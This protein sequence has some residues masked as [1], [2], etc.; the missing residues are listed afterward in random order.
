M[1]KKHIIMIVCIIAM[2]F[3]GCQSTKNLPPGHRRP[4]K[5]KI[6]EVSVEAEVA[7]INLQERV[8]TLKDAE[9]RLVTLQV[10]NHVKRFDEIEKGD[11]VKAEYTTYLLSEF[12]D[13][14]P[15]EYQNPLVVI[16]DGVVASEDLPPE[17]AAGILVKAVVTVEA[18]DIDAKLVAVKGPRGRHVILPAEDISLL[19][20]LKI[21]ERVVITYIEAMALSLEKI[22]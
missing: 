22:R 16:S 20:D 11:I 2:I 8:L 9:G 10:G 14:T 15:E 1:K 5:E 17:V 19:K 6:S 12:R 3:T 13:P 4:A 18:I 21:G 7:A